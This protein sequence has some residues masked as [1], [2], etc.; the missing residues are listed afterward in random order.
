MIWKQVRT[1][2]LTLYVIPPLK[3]PLKAADSE[4]CSSLYCTGFPPRWSS[5]CT[6]KMA[7]AVLSSWLH[8][9]PVRHK[10]CSSEAFPSD[11]GPQGACDVLQSGGPLDLSLTFPSSHPLTHCWSRRPRG[12]YESVGTSSERSSGKIGLIFLFL[13]AIKHIYKSV[14]LWSKTNVFF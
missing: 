13:Y 3:Y 9:F 11:C 8:S 12:N 10:H 5:S 14:Y 1:P 4:P 2:R 6:V 7:A